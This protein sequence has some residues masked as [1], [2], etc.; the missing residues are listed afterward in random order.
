MNKSAEFSSAGSRIE[1]GENK[2]RYHLPCSNMFEWRASHA[3]RQHRSTSI[4]SSLQESLLVSVSHGNSLTYSLRNFLPIFCFACCCTVATSNEVESED[5]SDD[6]TYSENS[7]TEWYMIV[8]F[9]FMFSFFII[10]FGVMIAYFS[11]MEDLLMRRYIEKGEVI[12]GDVMSVEYARGGGRVG[13]CSQSRQ[14]AEYITFV[15]YTRQLSTSYTARVRKQMKV[16][17]TDFLRPLL[18]GTSAMLQRM[19][20]KVGDQE[21]DQ[22]GESDDARYG[23]NCYESYYDSGPVNKLGTFPT[24]DTIELY[25]LP[26]Y[27]RSGYPRHQ[28]E[29]RCCYRYRLSTAALI[30]FDL[31]LAAFCTRIATEAIED[32]D[33]IE[34]RK[35]AQYAIGIFV[36]LVAMQV[37]LIHCCMQKLFWDVLREE[38]LESG[39]FMPIEND[40]SS[41]SSAASDVYLTMSRCISPLAVQESPVLTA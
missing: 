4:Y 13:V 41:L 20:I 14:S 39:E 21:S 3:R 22:G 35:V 31:A 29:R 25:I 7:D 8:F 26:D 34:Q 6:T 18:P 33:N 2:K 37:P 30:A 23:V 15:E 17:E 16:R 36:I 19:T 10:L 12:R 27:P 40:D 9:S 5:I 38:Y 1:T 11:V 24:T 28:V 32:L